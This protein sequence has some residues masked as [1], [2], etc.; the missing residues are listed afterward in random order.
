VVVDA[1]AARLD[2]APFFELMADERI[3][4]VFH[5]GRQDIE[6]VWHLASLVPQPVFDTQIAAMVLGHGESVSYEQIVHRL[7]GAAIDKS[8][9]FTDWSRRPLSDAQLAYAAA[10]VTHLRGVYRALAAQLEK[11][12][13]ADW[14]A[15]EM[16]VLTS[17]DTY[18]QE[19]EQAWRRIKARVKKPKELAILM[20]VAAWREREAQTRDVPRSRVLKDDAVA[21]VAQRAP[22]SV[23]ALGHL[24]AV[25]NGFERSR[26]GADI[27]AAVERGLARDPET[28]PP[29]ERARPHPP[30]GG[31]T[32]ELLKVLLKLVAEH[33]G[34]A[35]K[36]LAT[37]D[38]L[39]LIAGDDAA[40]VAALHGWRRELFGEKALRLKHG[41][42]ALAMRKGRVVTL[43]TA[44]PVKD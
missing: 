3:L 23:A 13:R 22:A 37:T 30:G 12:G 35:S 7:T 21:E 2:L 14:V 5:S 20:E 1:L 38:D 40:E 10:D 32:V 8:S 15:E 11:R 25:P 28:L 31:A 17:P 18:R 43:D 33:E 4:K 27:V 26:M 24:R 29:L 42:L 44:A 41:E 34:V 16:A 36:V 19:P 6:I 9:R 39:E